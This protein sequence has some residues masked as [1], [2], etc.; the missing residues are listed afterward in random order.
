MLNYAVRRLLQMVLVLFLVSLL[1]FIFIK[2]APGDPARVM[3]GMTATPETVETIREKFGLDRP[4]YVQFGRLLA[5]LFSG[6]L[7]SLTYRAPIR[8]LV[9]ER[10]KASIELGVFALILTVVIS[11][12]FGIISALKR[13]TPVDYGISLLAL[14]GI[15]TPVFWLAIILMSVFGVHLQILPISGRGATIG[16]W[17]FLTID[18]LRHLIIP[19]VALATVQLALN[20][21]LTRSSIL[22]VLNQDYLRTA[23]A[24]GVKGSIVIFKHAF[25]N[26]M[27]PV[28]TNVGIQIGGFLGGAV[29]TE[30]VT[31]WPGL[32]RLMFEGISRR[33][34]PLIIGLTLLSAFAAVLGYVIV[35][36][37]Y[38]LVDPRITYE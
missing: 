26:A 12:P 8:D 2:M 15:S 37:L 14:I 5:G 11:I 31:A 9:I 16:G 18:G 28:L 20:T 6:E 21:R 35:D 33:D 23:R 36:L 7:K 19:A 25:R 22:E 29:L 4:Y 24:K 1:V 27:L 13:S 32:G 10:S 3:A 38:A 30:T 34:E 17:S